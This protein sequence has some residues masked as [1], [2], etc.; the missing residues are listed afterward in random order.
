MDLNSFG[1]VLTFAEEIEQRDL[2]FYTDAAAEES[3]GVH[4]DMYDSFIRENKKNIS[5]IQ[6]TRRE[7]VTEMILEPIRHF[8]R[9][10]YQLQ[11][12]PAE[13]NDATAFLD[14]ANARE[15]R[16]FTFYTDGADKLRSLAEVSRSLKLLAK[17]HKRRLKLINNHA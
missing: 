7:N 16:A 9:K 4:R 5:L 14:I 11:E 17:K 15:R 10:N 2:Q 1:A 8:Y 3:V 12:N 13:G 6:R